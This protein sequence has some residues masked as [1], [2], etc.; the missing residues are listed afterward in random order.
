[1][2]MGKQIKKVQIEVGEWYYCGCY[3]QQQ[4]HPSLCKYVVFKD[5]ATQTHVGTSN[6]MV[7]A[8]E[9]CRQNKVDNPVNGLKA[10]K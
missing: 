9:L 1:M 7:Y 3:I 10:Y 6:S 4:N 2:D 5:D 8:M